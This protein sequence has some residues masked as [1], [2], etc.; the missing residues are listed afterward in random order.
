[1]SMRI[2]SVD[3]DAEILQGSTARR[4]VSVL[5]GRYQPRPVQP[6]KSILYHLLYLSIIAVLLLILAY[7]NLTSGSSS[8]KNMDEIAKEMRKMGDELNRLKG[9]TENTV[10]QL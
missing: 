2:S 9:K 8:N 7:T 4:N 10:Q 3:D 6:R 5:S 1:M